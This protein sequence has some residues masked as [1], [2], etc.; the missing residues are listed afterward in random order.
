MSLECQGFEHIVPLSADSS[1]LE[2]KSLCSFLHGRVLTARFRVHPK[3]TPVRRQR[4]LVLSCETNGDYAGMLCRSS[5]L[6]EEGQVISLIAISEGSYEA[7]QC[8]KRHRQPGL[9]PERHFDPLADGDCHFLAR[10]RRNFRINSYPIREYEFH[11]VLW[12][13]YED[14]VAYRKG[15][16]RVPKEIWDRE[17]LGWVD[18][19]LG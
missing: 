11:D 10:A 13:E 12:V 3:H 1:T 17:T 14:G 6:L 9:F 15:I 19:T 5:D 4:F 2:V 16:G 7:W 18:V 8:C